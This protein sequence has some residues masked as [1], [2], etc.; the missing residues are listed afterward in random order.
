VN[1]SLTLR[2][3][4]PLS[5][6]IRSETGV[7]KSTIFDLAAVQMVLAHAFGTKTVRAYLRT[8]LL[9]KRREIMDSW[10]DYCE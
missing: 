1:S 4:A 10:A 9:E 5:P 2:P 3:I 6:P 7:P 8:D